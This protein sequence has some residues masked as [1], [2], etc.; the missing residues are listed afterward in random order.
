MTICSKRAFLSNLYG[1][2]FGI[3]RL[4]L[5]VQYLWQFKPVNVWTDLAQEF[6]VQKVVW[7]FKPPCLSLHWHHKVGGFLLCKRCGSRSPISASQ[8]FAT[9]FES[10]VA[11]FVIIIEVWMLLCNVIHQVCLTFDLM[12]TNISTPGSKGVAC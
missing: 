2:T 1:Q 6:A 5:A 4:S 8:A 11:C 10:S 3:T 7:Q 9:L 12:T